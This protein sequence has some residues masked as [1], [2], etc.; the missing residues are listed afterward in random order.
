MYGYSLCT[1]T[2]ITV[3]NEIFMVKNLLEYYSDLECDLMVVKRYKI[4]V[5]HISFIL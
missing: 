1:A 4:C 5:Q 3:P 2:P